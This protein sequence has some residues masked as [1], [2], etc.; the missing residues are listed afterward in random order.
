MAKWITHLILLFQPE[1]SY[2]LVDEK[3]SSAAAFGFANEKPVVSIKALIWTVISIL[4][5]LALGQL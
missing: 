4:A 1:N 3:Y 2:R 5:G